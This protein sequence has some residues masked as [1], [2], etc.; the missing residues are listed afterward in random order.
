M[1]LSVVLLTVA[2]GM[3][4]S[5]IPS[6]YKM[7]GAKKYIERLEALLDLNNLSI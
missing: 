5:Y 2:V 1:K 3:A 6:V 4:W 7:Y